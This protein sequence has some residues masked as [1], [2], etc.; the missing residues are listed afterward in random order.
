MSENGDSCACGDNC[1]DKDFIMSAMFGHR[2]AIKMPMGKLY[3]YIVI[4]T[5]QRDDEHVSFW[6]DKFIN[7]EE[8]DEVATRYEVQAVGPK[9][10]LDAAMRIDAYR[11]ASLMTG[12][13]AGLDDDTTLDDQA[14][15]LT[16][17]GNSGL[18][19]RMFFSEPTSVQVVM[20]ENEDS[21][22]N[23]SITEVMNHTEHTGDLAE[24]WLKEQ[25]ENG[26]TK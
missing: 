18:F 26:D 16:N 24:Q 25:D 6:D 14:T 23:R 20:K 19:N 5:Y 4:I 12:W 11:K 2:D 1:E 21:M 13:I 17:M 15:I 8:L 22:I 10:A 9:E 7:L 3:D